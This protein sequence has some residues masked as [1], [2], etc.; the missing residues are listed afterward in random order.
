MQELSIDRQRH[1]PVAVEVGL[2]YDVVGGGNS[3]GTV[4]QVKH[5]DVLA[6]QVEIADGLREREESEET[7]H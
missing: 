7:V 6:M 1:F 4:L 3:R 5:A 2:R